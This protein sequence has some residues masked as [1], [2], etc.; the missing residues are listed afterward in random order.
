MKVA[1][2][3][4]KVLFF[5]QSEDVPLLAY[6]VSDEQEATVIPIL[7]SPQQG[8]LPPPLASFRIFSSSGF[9]KLE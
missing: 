1:G 7:L 5:Q 3:N 6:T 4:E 9:L 8:V 2:V